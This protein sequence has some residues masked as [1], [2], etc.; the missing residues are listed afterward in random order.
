MKSKQI[1]IYTIAK[2]LRQ[3]M[4]LAEKVLCR[5]QYTYERRTRQKKKND[6]LLFAVEV[7]RGTEQKTKGIGRKS[8]EL[9]IEQYLAFVE[10]NLFRSHYGLKT[11][12]GVL[13][14]LRVTI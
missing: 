2:I 5:E 6:I 14:V 7:D 4:T 12:F 9:S 1:S 8:Y 10:R 11:V 3:N 13:F